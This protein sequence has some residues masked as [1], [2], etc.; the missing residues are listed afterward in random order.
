VPRR[1]QLKWRRAPPAAAEAGWLL[2]AAARA[3]NGPGSYAHYTWPSLPRDML[4]T[5]IEM[6]H[7][8]T[9][10]PNATEV[11]GNAVF[12]STQMWHS[13]GVGGYFGTQTWRQADGTMTH[14]ALFR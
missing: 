10:M 9:T 7:V 3:A 13:T 2:V 11:H 12:A 5:S 8:W 4:A 1:H 14:R 6:T